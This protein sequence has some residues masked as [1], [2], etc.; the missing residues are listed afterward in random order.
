MLPPHLHNHASSVPEGCR[1]E[2]LGQSSVQI[3]EFRMA[4]AIKPTAIPEL[5]ATFF[6]HRGP[7]LRTSIAMV[8]FLRLE[9][10]ENFTSLASLAEEGQ[11]TC[12]L[13]LQAKRRRSGL[14][15]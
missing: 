9:A 12:R 15:S 14:H 1:H 10:L 13:A 3:D 7:S 6:Q 4:L 11:P 5:T 8:T 2:R